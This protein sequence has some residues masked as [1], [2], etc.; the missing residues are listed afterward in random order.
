MGKEKNGD[1]I[2]LIIDRQLEDKNSIKITKTSRSY[3][4]EI[5]CYEKDLDKA[6]KNVLEIRKKIIKDIEQWN[7]EETVGG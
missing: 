4:F 2:H 5:K 7:K 6:R 3:N 1:V